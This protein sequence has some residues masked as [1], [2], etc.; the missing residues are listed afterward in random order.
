MRRLSEGMYIVDNVLNKERMEYFP[1]LWH[2]CPKRGLRVELKLKE[3]DGNILT[4]VC[5]HCEYEFKTAKLR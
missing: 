4:F 1:R 5:P 2:D 3:E